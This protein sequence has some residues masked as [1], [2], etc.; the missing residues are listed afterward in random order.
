MM[1]S[2]SEL[3]EIQSVL[4]ALHVMARGRQ[5]GNAAYIAATRDTG[6]VAPDAVLHRLDA[7]LHPICD[8][9]GMRIGIEELRESPLAT[10]CRQCAA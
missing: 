8:A 5:L 9:C 3:K 1:K 2:M 4:H 10:R 6:E 7:G